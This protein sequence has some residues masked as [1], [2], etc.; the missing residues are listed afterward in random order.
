MSSFFNVI[1]T[2][3]NIILTILSSSSSSSILL[4]NEKDSALPP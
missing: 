2:K 4:L 3:Y 1:D